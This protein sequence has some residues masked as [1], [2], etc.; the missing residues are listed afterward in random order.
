[1]PVYEYE[2]RDCRKRFDVKLSVDERKEVHCPECGARARRVMGF[3]IKTKS[4]E[5]H[6]PDK[7]R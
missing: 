2:C 3:I 6:G 7:A 1:M 4:W 5:L